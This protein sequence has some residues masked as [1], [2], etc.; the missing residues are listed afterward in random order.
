G[1]RG[2][3]VPEQPEP[4]G[5][6]VVGGGGGGRARRAGG[7]WRRGARGGRGAHGRRGTRG[8]LG[9]H[10]GLGSRGGRGAHG[11]RGARGGRGSR[12]GGAAHGECNGGAE[13]GVDAGRQA[14]QLGGAGCGESGLAVVARSGVDGDD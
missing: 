4:L 6:G 8:G 10:G 13:R 1:R 3:V 11:G 9:A 12:G 5:V 14:D 7:C 2:A